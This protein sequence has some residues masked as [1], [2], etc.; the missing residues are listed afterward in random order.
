[1]LT[2]LTKPQ[3]TALLESAKDMR[4][5]LKRAIEIGPEDIN[6]IAVEPMLD[7][8]GWTIRDPRQIR[9]LG[10]G[11]I[12]LL[13]RGRPA[14]RVRSVAAHEPL[15]GSLGSPDLDDSSWIIVTNGLD[16][17]IFNRQNPARPFRSL[18][19]AT[20]ASDESSLEVLALLN[21]KNFKPEALSEA[22]MSEAMDADV[23]RALMRHLDGSEALV[24]T[25][26]KDLSKQG[27]R[28]SAEEIRA[29][30][31]R[32]DIQ[33]PDIPGDTPAAPV[34]TAP[35]PEKKLAA[36]IPAK[37]APW[38]KGTS[39]AMHRKQ[40]RAYVSYDPKT[41]EAKLL[42]GSVLTMDK[43]KTLTQQLDTMREE[44]RQDGTLE[45]HNDLL[46]VTKPVLFDTIRSAASFAAATQV[47]DL[48][49]WKTPKGQSLADEVASQSKPAKPK[50]K[51]T[52][53]K[54]TTPKKQPAPAAAQPIPEPPVE[55]APEIAASI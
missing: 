38:P 48:S 46:L 14:L 12:T 1:M 22:W 37:D 30:L 35:A 50:P 10:G 49:V 11:V 26:S 42:P 29:A 34:E 32:I 40:T 43:G 18:S 55:T 13:S 25:L 17:L 39:H 41:G 54:K 19:L 3:K 51:G 44:A 36:G 52:A 28:I 21:H 33:L 4:A 24:S 2:D 16:W 9:R 45:Q 8:L 27:L 6:A 15:P 31:S 47:K 7:A 53:R 23:T 20:A 5:H